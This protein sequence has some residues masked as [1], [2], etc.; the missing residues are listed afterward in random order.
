M[1]RT[2]LVLDEEILEEARRGTG[3][4]TYSAVVNYALAELI[5]RERFARIDEYASSGVWEGDLAEMRDDE[6]PR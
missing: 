1:K 5:R 3:L 2:N 6:L 4:K